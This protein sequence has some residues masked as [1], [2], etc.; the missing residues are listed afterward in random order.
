MSTRR[1]KSLITDRCRSHEP[2]SIRDTLTTQIKKLAGG[3]SRENRN[4]CGVRR[5]MIASSH[6]LKS[7]NRGVLGKENTR[8]VSQESSSAVLARYVQLEQRYK[9][10][11]RTGL[12]SELPHG[13]NH[14]AQHESSQYIVSCPDLNRFIDVSEKYL[15]DNSKNTPNIGKE[16]TVKNHDKEHNL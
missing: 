10:H 5:G 2:G 7:A 14:L 3:Q 12:G 1:Q 11:G 15:N 9:R 16:D 6:G 13:T 4:I 8:F